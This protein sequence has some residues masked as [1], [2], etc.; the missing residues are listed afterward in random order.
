MD[1]FTTISLLRLGVLSSSDSSCLEDTDLRFQDSISQTPRPGLVP[2]EV[3]WKERR[4]W[5]YTSPLQFVAVA[6]SYK[7]ADVEWPFPKRSS[8]SS[9]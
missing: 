4:D 8:P 6:A 1:S 9:P 7:A 5:V 3:S 2:W